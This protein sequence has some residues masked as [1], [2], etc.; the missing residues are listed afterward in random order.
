MNYNSIL[1]IPERALLNKRLTKAFFLKNFQLSP[2]EKKLLNNDISGMQWLA[3]VKPSNTNIS[4]SIDKSYHF[5]ELQVIVV[6][7]NRNLPELHKRVTELLQKHIPYQLLVIVE[8][9]EEFI[10]NAC[11]KR[12]NLNDSYKRTIETYYTTKAIP[13]LYKNEIT[14]QFFK[15][16]SFEE[17]NKTNLR[18]TYESWIQAIIQYK[19]ANLTGQFKKRTQKRTEEDM[20]LLLKIEAIDQEIIR[21]TNQ[22]KKETQLNNRVNLNVAIQLK[23]KEIENIKNTLSKE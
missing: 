22:I 3:S 21:L 14:S 4:E 12:V 2:V 5:E 7:L 9:T 15:N 20:N 17:L 23:R 11:D 6:T 13:K 19:S 10:I 18:T 8:N 1:H 16:L